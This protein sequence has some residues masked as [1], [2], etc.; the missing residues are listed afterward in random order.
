MDE[1]AT[2]LIRVHKKDSRWRPRPDSIS[3]SENCLP[4]ADCATRSLSSSSV[5]EAPQHPSYQRT[6]LHRPTAA[7]GCNS[8]RT[9]VTAASAMVWSVRGYRPALGVQLL[10]LSTNRGFPWW[11]W[12]IPNIGHIWLILGMLWV[13]LSA[14]IHKHKG[15]AARIRRRAYDRFRKTRHG[16]LGGCEANYGAPAETTYVIWLGQRV[17]EC[18]GKERSKTM[19]DVGML[20][21]GDN[22]NL[23]LDE[24]KASWVP[25]KSLTDRPEQIIYMHG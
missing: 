17:Q 5:A 23:S 13:L 15:I 20:L 24:F 4:G 2:K 3:G 25:G 1:E 16:N 12:G 10:D 18:H 14:A 9:L 6:A 11:L 22:R 8:C 21:N 19:E 7:V